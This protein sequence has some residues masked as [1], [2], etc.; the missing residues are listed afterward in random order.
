M[1]ILRVLY[2][3]KYHPKFYRGNRDLHILSLKPSSSSSSYPAHS[4]GSPPLGQPAC[5]ALS[6][7]PSSRLG[8]ALSARRQ[9]GP[10]HTVIV[11]VVFLCRS[12]T[13][14]VWHTRLPYIRACVRLCVWWRR[15]PDRVYVTLESAGWVR[16]P[17]A[18]AGPVGIP[19]SIEQSHFHWISTYAIHIREEEGL[20]HTR[21]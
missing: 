9:L 2:L 14:V 5:P 16:W 6:R 12:R 11:V 15:R 10:A 13:P 7:C 18:A 1:K 8:P 4:R 21:R 17:A 19:R 20:L 3:Q